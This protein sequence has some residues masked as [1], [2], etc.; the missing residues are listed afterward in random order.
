[1]G[2]ANHTVQEGKN[3]HSTAKKELSFFKKES[4]KTGGGPQP[5]P[6]LQS[7]EQIIEIFEDTP[8]FA[9][10]HGFETVSDKG[11]GK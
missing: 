10:L 6:P 1:M 7:R 3:L 11:A 2:R 9:G 5:K 8:T 4:K